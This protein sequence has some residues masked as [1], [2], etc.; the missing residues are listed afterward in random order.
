M[1][2]TFIPENPK[3]GPLSAL[4]HVPASEL[5]PVVQLVERLEA[6]GRIAR[7]G[8][9]SIVAEMEPDIFQDIVANI[10]GWL[11]QEVQM[12]SNTSAFEGS[13]AHLSA[14]RQDH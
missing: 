1:K 3:H 12:S 6:V 14:T 8:R 7:L 13:L 4:D 5:I 2:Y 11:A 10:P 9:W